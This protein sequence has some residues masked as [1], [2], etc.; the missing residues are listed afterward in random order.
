ML[1]MFLEIVLSSASQCPSSRESWIFPH[2]LSILGREIIHQY[3][4]SVA[5]VQ[6]GW[7]DS[8]LF[9]NFP[10]TAVHQISTACPVIE[11][12]KNILIFLNLVHQVTPGFPLPAHHGLGA[13]SMQSV[14]ANI[15]LTSFIPVSQGLVSFVI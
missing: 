14:G 13:L 15:G 5:L 2:L 6:I 3:F 4:S 7:E 12:T 10:S 11:T 9:R 1:L 8:L